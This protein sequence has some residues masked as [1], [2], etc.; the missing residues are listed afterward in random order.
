M[1][2]IR[3][4]IVSVLAV[5]IFCSVHALCS[6]QAQRPAGKPQE[7]FAP[8]W[9]A[10][11]GW[12]TELQLKN[13]LTSGSLS[14]T[15]VLRL[16]SGKEI[17]LDP[18]T[19][20]PNVSVSVWVNEGLTKHSPTLMSQIGSY[21]SVIFRFTS[22]S[23]RNLYAASLLSLYGEPIKFHVNA[24]PTAISQPL[25]KTD[26]PGSR[27]GI[28]WQPRPGLKDIL[29]ISNSSQTN[30]RGTLSLFDANGKQ[31]SETLSLG[32]RQTQRM[33]VSD[34]VQ[35][36]G[37]SGNYGGI[38]FEVPA[39]APALAS[40]H[41]LYDESSGFSSILDMFDRDPTATAEERIGVAKRQWTMWAPMLAL[42]S[43]DPAIG[44]PPRTVLQ[45]TI[46]VRN[47]TAKSVSATITLTWREE[48]ERGQVKLPELN[49]A[50]FAT[51]RLQIGTIQKQLGIPDDAHW[52]LVTLTSPT[53]PDNL[54]AIASSYDS[55]GRYSVETRFSDNLGGRFVGGEWRADATHNQIVVVTNAGEKATD[56]LFTLHYDNGEKKYEIRQTIQPGDQMWLNFANLI[57]NRV[58]DRKGN[59]LPVDLEFGTHDLEDLNRGSG[60]L[61][62]GNLM[63][64]TAWGY[65]IIPTSATCCGTQNPFFSPNSFEF[66]LDGVSDPLAFQGVDDCTGDTIDISGL[67]TDWWSSNTTIALVKPRIVQS[68]SSGFTFGNGA[69]EVWEGYG[70]NCA[71]VKVYPAAQINVLSATVTLRATQN[72]TV[73]ATDGAS[74]LY[75]G[76]V[77]S[78]NLGLISGNWGVNNGCVAGSELV[79]AV[80]PSNYTGEVIVKRTVTSEGCYQGLKAITCASAGVGD[81]TG[82]WYTS[83]PQNNT[84]GGSASGHVYNLD[85]PGLIGLTTLSTPVRVRFNFTAHAVDASGNRISPDVN[86]FARLS[87][88]NNSSGVAQLKTDASSSDNQIGLGSTNTTW[89]LK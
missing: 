69:A 32:G 86:Y 9:T 72:T 40:L 62:E 46:F 47:A 4:A 30:I 84:P 89:D 19:I 2:A 77:G 15:P 49:L 79:G 1:L 42:R 38:K 88:M 53:S 85:A 17:P 16:A 48:S 24:Y 5:T 6:N 63:L 83:N 36:A 11:P 51:Q 76:F 87:C 64:D 22:L 73:S 44:L 61:M 70:N 78:L 81:D 33:I 59:I 13:N 14:V 23:A 31:W 29:V 20:A 67:I 54:M 58:P 18:V 52:A 57:H 3:R 8:Y 12:E 25:V 10:E 21:G 35:A 43:P 66:W 65:K 45:P 50:P 68:V 28:W 74:T 39:A 56:A 27:E 26:R 7:V 80:T 37:L 71:F 41:F 60:S 34:L 55:T 82:N 75:K